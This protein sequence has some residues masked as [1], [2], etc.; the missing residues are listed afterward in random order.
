MK[1]Q[2]VLSAPRSPWQRA[3][4]ERVIGSIPRECLDHMIVFSEESLRRIL[5]SYFA[6]YHGSRTHLGLGKDTPDPRPVQRPEVGRV[7]AV[8][9]VGGLHHRNER[10]ALTVCFQPYGGLLNQPDE[11]KVTTQ[12]RYSRVLAPAL[13]YSMYRFCTDTLFSTRFMRSLSM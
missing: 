6:Y 3:Y 8:A 13:S 1:I 12:R 11:H 2:E 9:Q 7:V 4:V 10:T 5:S